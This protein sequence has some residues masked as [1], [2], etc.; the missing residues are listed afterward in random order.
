METQPLDGYDVARCPG[1]GAMALQDLALMGLLG[2]E[3]GADRL[4]L[5]SELAAIG[6][7]EAVAACPACGGESVRLGLLHGTWIGVCGAC[8]TVTLPAGALD[9][10]RWKV[11]DARRAELAEVLDEE[12]AEAWR[13]SDSAILGP[14]IDA[15]AAAVRWWRRVAARRAR[16]RTGSAAGGEANRLPPPPGSAPV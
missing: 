11:E 3:G 12:A 14:L 16:R 2:A 8:R 9:E 5:D 10:L 6:G 15:A 1:C 13:S 7:G 4:L